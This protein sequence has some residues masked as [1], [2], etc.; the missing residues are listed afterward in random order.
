M[1]HPVEHITEQAGGAHGTGRALPPRTADAAQAGVPSP[2]F[3][4]IFL[5]HVTLSLPPIGLPAR[6]YYDI[7]ISQRKLTCVSMNPIRAESHVIIQ[8]FPNSCR[9]CQSLFTGSASFVS[10][11][12]PLV[13]RNIP[14]VGGLCP[15]CSYWLCRV[16]S[17]QYSSSRA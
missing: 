16:G 6:L 5:V 3:P 7:Y 11:S 2:L 17:S 8:F 13:I 14:L 15:T 9:M 12:E 1:V 10:L 4:H